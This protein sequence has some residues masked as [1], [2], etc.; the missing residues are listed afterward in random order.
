MYN[1]EGGYREKVRSYYLPGNTPAPPQEHRAYRSTSNA[2]AGGSS[3]Q[4]LSDS[5]AERGQS[6]TTLLHASRPAAEALREHSRMAVA[7]AG[8]PRA[9]AS[10]AVTS[11]RPEPMSSS[12]GVGDIV[13]VSP[14]PAV[15]CPRKA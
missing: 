2:A 6:A 4:A 10:V 8:S 12:V 5:L 9:E 13:K 1:R 11:P 15:R 3:V 7:N 14:N